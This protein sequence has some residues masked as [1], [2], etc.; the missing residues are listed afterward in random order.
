M[1]ELVYLAGWD[2]HEIVVW[3]AMCKIKTWEVALMVLWKKW[4]HSQEHTIL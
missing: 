4:E 2:L 3:G 1:W